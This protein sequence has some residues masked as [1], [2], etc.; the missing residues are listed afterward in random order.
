MTVPAPDKPIRV[1]TIKQILRAQRRRRIRKDR[2]RA[3]KARAA[4]LAQ[5]M[6]EASP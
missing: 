2:R 4:A 6:Q 1:R 5:P 3:A